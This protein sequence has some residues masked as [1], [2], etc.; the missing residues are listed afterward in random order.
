MWQV[1]ANLNKTWKNHFL[2][3]RKR[4]KRGGGERRQHLH[5][6]NN[7][8]RLICLCW[9]MTHRRG[10]GQRTPPLRML[11]EDKKEVAEERGKEAGQVLCAVSHATWLT[12]CRVEGGNDA[13]YLK[14]QRMHCTPLAALGGSCRCHSSWGSSSSRPQAQLAGLWWRWNSMRLLRVAIIWLWLP[15]KRFECW[16]RKM[17]V[18]PHA[19]CCM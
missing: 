18:F 9:A 6:K 14:S 1:A 3:H 12:Q 7:E 8:Q 16:L 2:I 10:R 4:M 17:L 5:L 19:A 15:P 13:F 11:K